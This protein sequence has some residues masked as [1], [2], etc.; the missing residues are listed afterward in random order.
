MAQPVHKIRIGLLNVAI[1][2][3]E[4]QTGVWYSVTPSRSYQK[5][6]E[7]KE[8]DSYGFDDLLTIAKLVDQAHSWIARQFQAEQKVRKVREE[9]GNDDE[10]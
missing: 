1:W 6:E 9:A 4:S 2:K 5:G 7:W 10:A 8:S 3:N